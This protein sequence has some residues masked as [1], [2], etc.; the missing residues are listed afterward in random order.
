[1]RSLQNLRAGNTW[2]AVIRRSSAYR[3][4]AN[5]RSCGHQHGTPRTTEDAMQQDQDHRH[6]STPQR[7]N[8]THSQQGVHVLSVQKRHPRRL[9]IPDVAFHVLMLSIN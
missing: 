2:F 8:Q 7:G 1:M 5:R 4:L 6:I 3:R 9:V